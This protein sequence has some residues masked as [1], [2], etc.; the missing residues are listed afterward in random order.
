MI[1]KSLIVLTPVIFTLGYYGYDKN[2]KKQ[3]P[4]NHSVTKSGDILF[5]EGKF[6]DALDEYNTIEKDL[7]K[8]DNSDTPPA[9]VWIKMADTFFE[10]GDYQQALD[11]YTKCFDY[12]KTSNNKYD[13]FYMA[14][15]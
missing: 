3:V 5:F 13:H 6:K 10:I 4:L 11:F 2:R 9:M 1:K 12:M 14:I 8:K 15:A 7:E